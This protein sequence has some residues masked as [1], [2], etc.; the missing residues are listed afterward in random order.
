M[1]EPR[2]EC[3]ESR[4]CTVLVVEDE[5]TT[6][7]LACEWYR[8][9]GGFRTEIAGTLAHGLHRLS[10]KSFH[11]VLLDLNLPDSFGIDTLNA[12]ILHT[13]DRVPVIVWTG[14]MTE[15]DKIIALKHGAENMLIKTTRG[16]EL[17]A[18]SRFAIARHGAKVALRERVE[19]SEHKVM[20]LEKE[21]VA[22]EKANDDLRAL[23]VSAS[24]ESA[25]GYSRS[26][27]RIHEIIDTMETAVKSAQG[28]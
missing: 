17:V 11:L 8:V 4:P 14:Y 18:T 27:K 16:D 2:L 5:P 21:K 9:S 3:T 24:V 15:A 28:V 19:I 23:Q 25:E 22:L 1:P 26:I 12:I 10:E 6:A 7:E 20:D 13:S